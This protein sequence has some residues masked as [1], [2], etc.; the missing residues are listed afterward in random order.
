[1]VKLSSL[2][3]EQSV[4]ALVE[5]MDFHQFK[6]RPQKVG[7]GTCL[8]PV[9]GELPFA[10][11]INETITAERVRAIRSQRVLSGLMGNLSAQNLSRPNCWHYV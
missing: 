1:M 5:F 9:P 3:F 10:A 6:A 8:I 7:Q 2:M 11:R 4:Q